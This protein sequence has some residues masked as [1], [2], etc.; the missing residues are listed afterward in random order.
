MTRPRILWCASVLLGLALAASSAWAQSG[1]EPPPTDTKIE[2]A[3]AEACQTLKK[4][5]QPDGGWVEYP[6]HEGA[7]TSLAVQ[8]LLL[9][10]EPYDSVTIR[11]AI[12]ALGAAKITRTYVMGCRAMAY[13]QLVRHYPN[14][15][16][17]LA[18]DATWLARNQHDDGM[19][20][21]LVKAENKG[22]GDNSVTGFAVLGLCDA[23]MANCEVSD[24]VW[25]KLFRHYTTTQTADGGWTYQPFTKA[26]PTDPDPDASVTITGPSLASLM[27]AS[28]QLLRTAGCPCAK[29]KS[30]GG[31][32]D[33]TI[34]DKGIQWMVD[35]FEGKKKSHADDR[36]LT[37]Y[38]Y[39]LQ[40]AGQA[41]GLKN[42]GKHDWY[43][44]GAAQM[45]RLAKSSGV[46]PLV[47]SIDLPGEKP[48]PNFKPPQIIT[49]TDSKGKEKQYV[50]DP[51]GIVDVS[52]AIIFLVKG[53]APVLMNKLKYDGDWNRHR[54]DLALLA[55]ETGKRLERQFRW[56][57]I[58]IKSSTKDWHD[59]PLMYL[60]GE[61]ALT[62]T[63]EDKEK[64]KQ[65][66]FEGG[67][68]LVEANCANSAFSQQARALIAEL[69]PD[70]PLKPL[71]DDH[72][73]YS[74]QLPIEAK[75]LLE[76]VDDGVRTFCL[77]T[78]KDVSCAWQMQDTVN[79]KE[80]FDLVVNLY[81]Y[82]TDKAPAPAKLQDTIAR[83]Q[84]KQRLM[85]EWEKAVAAEKEAAKKEKRPTK[86]IPKTWIE[87]EEV[88]K[89]SKV[90]TGG[91]QLVN[92]QCLAHKG[93]YQLGLHYQMLG[94]IINEF[95]TEA[96]VTIA[97]GAASPADE[98][99]VGMPDVLVVRGGAAMELT[100]A[101]KDYLAD[102]MKS[103]GFV[104][105][106]AAMGSKSFD[107]DFRTFIAGAEGLDLA[108]M[109]AG[110]PF[111]KGDM[112]SSLKGLEIDNP[113]F[114][115]AV[116]EEHPDIKTPMI[117]RIVAGDRTVGYYSPL[118]LTY[119][120]SGYGAYNLRGYDRATAVKMLVNMLLMTTRPEMPA[121][122]GD[123]TGGET[124]P[125]K[126][127][128]PKKS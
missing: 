51:N 29:G 80:S 69:W 68:L 18:A 104:I 62:L 64:L 31:K 22:R 43:K 86:T 122:Q 2:E 15:R 9:A 103:G 42:F 117:L 37:Y 96:G 124:K 61:E 3:I 59:S 113:R 100:D 41:S 10:G 39:G 127:R 11:Q 128:K 55:Q 81:A 12:E 36:Y 38:W 1:I 102:Y 112:D 70:W 57:V 13:A 24:S 108:P 45:Y 115:R 93:N 26:K 56:Q 123:T 14:L 126:P 32:L 23:S 116:R 52:L 76:G 19:W 114:S 47:K 48:D 101:E 125:K 35:Y 74:C 99:D 85:D 97:M 6:Q 49:I 91:R 120:A 4:L 75:G 25:T 16:H 95:Q 34:L 118:D 83:L 119:S 46:R 87:K 111:F 27:I 63:A 30:S 121:G 17:R 71:A 107:E 94:L 98:I 105:A 88:I 7:T 58:D 106:E 53:N 66:C 109:E 28:D 78:D 60:S 40:R 82:A 20:G 21:Y 50:A 73:L 79:R 8:A 44:R 5:Q 89:V 65:F 72:P 67:T 84:E 33:N 54:R 90:K 77:F 110:D 92:M